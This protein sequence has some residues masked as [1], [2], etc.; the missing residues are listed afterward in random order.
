MKINRIIIRILMFILILALIITQTGCDLNKQNPSPNSSEN[1]NKGISMSRF[2]LDTVC[3]LTVYG[4][5][6]EVNK[7]AEE[8]INRAFDKINEYEKLLSY[9]REESEISSINR[10]KGE[11]TKVS[12]DV[13]EVIKIGVEYS[14]LSKGIFDISCGALTDLWDFHDVDSGKSASGK[15]PKKDVVEEALKHIGYEKIKLDLYG[16]YVTL[17]DSKMKL[18]LGGVAK[19]YIADKTAEFLEKEGVTSAIVDLGGNIVA[20]GSKARDIKSYGKDDE[21]TAFKLGV[22]DPLSEEGS[23][24]GMMEGGNLTLVTSGTYERYFEFGGKRYHHI[25]STKNGFPTDED[26]LQVTII[27]KR[28]K[29]AECDA[30]STSCLALGIEKGIELVNQAN[31][32]AG[33]DTY[34]AIFLSREGKVSYSN[35]NSKF[36]TSE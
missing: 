28:G 36:I 5:N 23:L 34:E 19:G 1:V 35:P 31:K 27:S 3:S 17:K 18:N 15:V 22:K 24:L 25:L 16:G 21:I 20:V 9:T 4:I 8:I 11:A 7:E 26:V 32:K 30:L 33:K 13:L 6:P 29:S 10:A 14:K 2:A 12:K